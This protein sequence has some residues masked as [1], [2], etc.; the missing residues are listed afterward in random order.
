M[1][2]TLIAGLA[3]LGVIEHLFLILPLRDAKLW[4]WAS[5]KVGLTKNKAAKTAAIE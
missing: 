4:S 5:S 2:G 1:T 3:A